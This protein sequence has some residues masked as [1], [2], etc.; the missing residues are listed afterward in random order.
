MGI[1]VMIIFH[2]SSVLIRCDANSDMLRN[3]VSVPISKQKKRNANNIF[4]RTCGMP[5]KW[6]SGVNSDGSILAICH[7]FIS[8]FM[9]GFSR[10][11]KILLCDCIRL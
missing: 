1:L 3:C 7:Y 6:K 2:L 8:M 5:R 4:V 11:D 10:N 9:V